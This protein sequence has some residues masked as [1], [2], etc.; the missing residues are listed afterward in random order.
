MAFVSIAQVHLSITDSVAVPP[1]LVDDAFGLSSVADTRVIGSGFEIQTFGPLGRGPLKQSLELKYQQS[2]AAKLLDQ[3]LNNSA[4]LAL[5]PA[6]FDARETGM[7]KIDNEVAS[8]V[9]P[10][11]VDL[12]NHFDACVEAHRSGEPIWWQRSTSKWRTL[13]PKRLQLIGF[14]EEQIAELLDHAG[15]PHSLKGAQQHPPEPG[16]QHATAPIAATAAGSRI[17]RLDE[18]AFDVNDL[19]DQQLARALE[20]IVYPTDL[21]ERRALQSRIWGLM[22]E[23][24]SGTDKPNFIESVHP[25]KGIKVIGWKLEYFSKEALRKRVARDFP[26]GNGEVTTEATAAAGAPD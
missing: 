13:D 7:A 1:T 8:L 11:L 4:K 6:W 17:H 10:A 19:Y 26:M 18:G 14:A 25:Q 22:I 5:G 12:A 16:V 2:M 20:Q 21:S 23:V 9:V 24:A 3:L 15:I